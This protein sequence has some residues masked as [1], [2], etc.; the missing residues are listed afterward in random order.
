MIMDNEEVAAILGDIARILE[1]EGEETYKIRAYRKASQS[2]ALLEGDINY[3]H[4]EGRLQEIPGVGRSIEGLIDQL[5]TTGKSDLYEALKKETPL[6]LYD[7][8]RV[9]GIGRKTALKVHRT[10]GVTTINEFKQAAKQHR[11]R[12]VRGLG[13]KIEKNILRSIEQYQRMESEVRIPLFRALGIAQETAGYLKDCGNID[14]L[15]IVGSIRRMAPLITDLNFLATSADPSGAI[16]CFCN[17]PVARITKNRTDTK[18]HITT[19]YR[20]EAT[21]EI[22]DPENIGLHMV[23]DTGSASHVR[24]LED[25]AA[26]KA[27]DFDH[28]SYMNA[29]TLE[30]KTLPREEDVYAALGLPYIP[31]EMREGRG[32]VEAAARGALPVPVE[33]SDIKG[34]LHVHSIWSDGSNAIRDIAMAARARGYEYVAIC[35]H[36]RSLTVANGLSIERLRDQMV[37]IDELNDTLEDFT[38][39][40]GS[41]V[42]IMADGSLDLPDDMLDQ[43]D[44]VVGSVHSS[45]KQEPNIITRRVLAAIESGYLT[46][47]GHPTS[48]V[49]GRREPT[50]VDIDQV[51]DA[52]AY[53]GVALEVNAYPDRLD[54]SDEN[55]KKA[56]D[57]GAV[58]AIDTDSHSIAELDFI[59]FGVANARRGWAPRERVLNCMAYEQLLQ[60]LEK[61]V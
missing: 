58:I 21:L 52:A 46:I 4:R 10:L 8:I 13:D 48:R 32:E 39:L 44:I 45:L 57:A 30:R 47:L 61:R 5:L 59:E 28:A 16:D 42:D 55:V 40:K 2:L 14:R 36:S 3:Y 34:D 22:V 37:E 31:P 51:I 1:L 11:I 54:L 24:A 38:V 23:I 33:R 7:V 12:N 53:H 60:F 19:R 27:I 25:L 56:M 43:L 41:E 29:I 35:D 9:P 18:A 20:V 6:E 15:E 50:L 49:I 26:K 17:S